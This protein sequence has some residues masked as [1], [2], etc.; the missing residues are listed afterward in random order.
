MAEYEERSMEDLTEEPSE[1]R[2]QDLREKGQVTQSRELTGT[3]ALL[4]IM[5]GVYFVSSKFVGELSELMKEIFSRDLVRQLEVQDWKAIVEVGGKSLRLLAMTFLP[6]GLAGLALA[7]MTALAQTGFLFAPELLNPDF[8]RVNP[9]NGLMRIFSLQNIVDQLKSILKLVVISGAIYGAL[10]AQIVTIPNVVSMSVQQIMA[11]IG[12]TTFRA[13]GTVAILLLAVAAL[14]YFIQ[15]RR[16]RKQAMMT[17]AEAKQEQKEREG[18]P[19]IKARIR[20]IQRDMARK[21][22]MKAIPKADVVI[23]NPTHIAIAVQYDPNEM[24]APKVL[25]KGADFLAER[26]KKV[27]REHGIPTVENKPLARTLYKYVKVGQ[28]IPRSLYQAVAE[29]LAYVYK[30]KGKKMGDSTANAADRPNR[31]SKAPQRQAR[32]PKNR[33]RGP[34]TNL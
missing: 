9:V 16:F 30:L 12:A 3:I 23:T 34:E 14:D 33:P 13:F 28:L 29:I 26:I 15:W 8:N 1:S 5:L 19:Q 25:A 4:G 20:S 17:K 7:V 10:K 22:M 31:P 11:Y 24:F 21:R 2:I 32:D 6:I 18:D 27:A